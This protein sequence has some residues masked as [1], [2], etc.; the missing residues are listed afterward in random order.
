MQ[1]PLLC[2][3]CLLQ[4]FAHDCIFSLARERTLSSFIPLSLI[5]QTGAGAELKWRSEGRYPELS[6]A[7]WLR[8]NEAGDWAEN[9]ATMELTY[10]G[11]DV[12][13][14]AELALKR[15]CQAC[16]RAYH[17][18]VFGQFSQVANLLL[19]QPAPTLRLDE[20]GHSWVVLKWSKCPEPDAQFELDY[21]REGASG[22]LT[23]KSDLKMTLCRKRNLDCGTVY[24][25]RVRV[26]AG[27]SWSKH[28]NTVQATTKSLETFLS[29]ISEICMEHA[30]EKIHPAQFCHPWPV[31]VRRKEILEDSVAIVHPM[32]MWMAPMYLMFEGEE[33]SDYGAL[34]REWVVCSCH[35][36]QLTLRYRALISRLPQLYIMC[37][38]LFL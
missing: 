27:G 38:C 22:W 3:V 2:Y 7:I 17:R 29:E 33:G 20:V 30:R 35:L 11:N 14:R 16:V 19:Q 5:T 4:A 21:L 1:V 32:H 37:T 13:G 10:T 9:A 26:C 34:H 24:Q 12:T 6:F 36:A 8:D 28:S 18:A 31:C 23:A 15:S 25:F